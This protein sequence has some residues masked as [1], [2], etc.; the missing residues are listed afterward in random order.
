[1]KAI[2]TRP[3]TLRFVNS[4]LLLLVVAYP[5]VTHFSVVDNLVWPSL[6]LIYAMLGLLILDALVGKKF[7][8]L[9]LCGIALALAVYFAEQGQLILNSYPVFII[10][11]LFVLFGKTLLPGET[12]IITSLAAL[13]EKSLSDRRVKYTRMLTQI[14]VGIFFCMLVES[15]LLSLYASQYTWS[16]FT[17]FINY[18]IVAFLLLAEYVLRI[19]LFRNE[20]HT[21]FI[22]FIN[23]L[24]KINISHVLQQ[25][26]S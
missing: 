21:G 5:V 17:N 15:L 7:I 26:K 23:R 6:A 16:L 19:Y 4:G 1:M 14:W 20:E 22:V 12:P 9:L 2:S 8:Y 3:D 11:G 13:I 10:G 18:L 24:R 25:K